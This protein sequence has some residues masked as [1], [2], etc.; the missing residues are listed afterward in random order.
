MS[1]YID[2]NEVRRLARLKQVRSSIGG[3]MTQH[4]GWQ[5]EQI[6]KR[7]KQQLKQRKL[8]A[9]KKPIGDGIQVDTSI[10]IDYTTTGLKL[11]LENLQSVDKAGQVTVGK[12][13][14]SNHNSVA[15]PINP[16]RRIKQQHSSLA[17]SSK[18]VG[19]SDKLNALSLSSST[20]SNHPAKRRSLIPKLTADYTRVSKSKFKSDEGKE[21]ENGDVTSF[22]QPSVQSTSSR[23]SYLKKPG[24][25]KHFQ[26]ATDITS[27]KREHADALQMLQELDDEEN[28]RRS[29][30]SA[31]SSAYSFN[32]EETSECDIFDKAN[33]GQDK[34]FQD[35]YGEIVSSSD[36]KSQPKPADSGASA[37][38]SFA[39]LPEGI[40][41]ASHLSIV[42]NDEIEAQE[43]V[44]YNDLQESNIRGEPQETDSYD[45]DSKSGSSLED[46]YLSDTSGY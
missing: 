17:T 41:D 22:D 6:E 15:L 33:R 9:K 32:S 34:K 20:N 38:D 5:R 11:K 44:E 39:W 30:G 14:K 23:T 26:L 37:D 24:P 7:R 29:L 46:E 8:Q 42:L 4:S 40:K 35:D 18:S 21:N 36:S 3:S 25:K 12:P 27:L 43:D 13:A 10:P 2:S 45:N 31:D 1:K 19:V 28:R 16:V